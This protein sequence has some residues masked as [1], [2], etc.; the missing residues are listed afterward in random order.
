MTR[1][2]PGIVIR[3]KVKVTSFLGVSLSIQYVLFLAFDTP[4]MFLCWMKVGEAPTLVIGIGLVHG[5]HKTVVCAS[6]CLDEGCMRLSLSCFIEQK[7]DHV[8]DLVMKDIIKVR[9]SSDLIYSGALRSM[10]N[11]FLRRLRCQ[12][13]IISMKTIVTLKGFFCFETES[14]TVTST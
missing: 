5:M 3:M 12:W 1:L 11:L 2:S 4:L 10:C 14:A 6:V 7:S 8:S 9:G 13:I